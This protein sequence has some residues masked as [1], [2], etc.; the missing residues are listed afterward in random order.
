M[1]CVTHAAVWLDKELAIEL[2]AFATASAAEEE[3]PAAEVEAFEAAAAAETE[4]LEA[5]ALA[6]LMKLLADELALAST[7]EALEEAA[8][9]AEEAEETAALSV[10]VAITPDAAEKEEQNPLAAATASSRF[11]PE[12]EHQYSPQPRKAPRKVWE[13]HRHCEA[14]EQTSEASE[15][16]RSAK[17]HL[18]PGRCTHAIVGWSTAV[19]SEGCMGPVVKATRSVSMACPAI[20]DQRKD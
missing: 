19:G 6:L 18:I 20:P 7:E 1:D 17:D 14:S 2:V 8:A 15:R 11:S 4:A 3:A 16:A 12:R 10:A 5:A 13:A 9:A